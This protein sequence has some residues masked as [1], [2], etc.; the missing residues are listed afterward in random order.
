MRATGNR[1]YITNLVSEIVRGF[2]DV[3]LTLIGGETSL[4]VFAEYSDNVRRLRVPF[5][6]GRNALRVVAEQAVV[7]RLVR[8]MGLHVFHGPSHV[9][10]L[11]LAR[12]MPLVLTILDFRYLHQPEAFSNAQ[13]IFR[14]LVYKRSMQAAAGILAISEFTK[15]EAIARFAIDPAKVTVGPLGVSAL[16]RPRSQD[17]LSELRRYGLSP[18]YVLTSGFLTH[19]R[20]DLVIEAAAHLRGM[21]LP[22]PRIVVLGAD[23]RTSPLATLSADLGVGDLVDF[24]GYV[25]DDALPLIYSGASLFVFPSLYEGFGLPILE[26]MAS[27]VPVIASK[28]A[29]IPEVS[30]ESALLLMDTRPSLLAQAMVRVQSDSA[31]REALIASGLQRAREFTWRRTAERTIAAYELAA[32]RRAA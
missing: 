10:P 4:R 30:G 21:R 3:Q 20:A 25:P 29:S 17:E 11:A 26:A 2:P 6:Q 13:R 8:G 16:Y 15:T 14:S 23:A 28:S 1:P 31:L 12:T 22:P 19:K 32:A 5:V 9:L 7:P 18:G 27:G 24:P